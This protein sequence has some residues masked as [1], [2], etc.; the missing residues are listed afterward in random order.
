MKIC[1]YEE[2]K[3]GENVAWLTR[4]GWMTCLFCF[5]YLNRSSLQRLVVLK[6]LFFCFAHLNRSSLQNVLLKWQRWIHINSLK[7][8]IK[9]WRVDWFSQYISEQKNNRNERKKVKNRTSK[10]H[11]WCLWFLRDRRKR[12]RGQ[13]SAYVGHGLCWVDGEERTI[14]RPQSTSTKDTQ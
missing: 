5:A 9:F 12:R 4:P 8:K 1:I 3:R 10:R 7:K 2:M 14:H 13:S 11:T 6:R